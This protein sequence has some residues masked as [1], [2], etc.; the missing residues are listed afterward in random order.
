MKGY[1]HIP[2]PEIEYKGKDNMLSKDASNI[3]KASIRK[4]SV[5]FD[6]C[7]DIKFPV[8][9]NEQIRLKSVCKKAD[10]FYK[11]IYGYDKKLTQT[12]FNTLLLQYA[13]KNE[14]VVNWDRPYKDSKVYM[15]T[16]PTEK[17][18]ELIGGPNGLSIKK[19]V[20][21]R[22]L[23]YYLVISVLELLESEE[24]YNGIIL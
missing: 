5:R 23:V 10:V 21:D 14:I 17:E 3:K 2:A 16:K 7:K 6:K 1:H 18:Y 19:A 4:R 13:L 12:H 8:S 15:H 11:G 9:K 24:E 20:S 22:K